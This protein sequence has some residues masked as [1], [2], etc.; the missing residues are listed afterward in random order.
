MKKQLII[1]ITMFI[2]VCF[3]AGC[4]GKEE[5]ITPVI[6]KEPFNLSEEKNE[7]NPETNALTASGSVIAVTDEET[8]GEQATQEAIAVSGSAIEEGFQSVDET[9]YVTE[10]S[11]R[12]RTS[13][14]TST[15]DNIYKDGV[16]R[17]YT[18]HR[19]GIGDVWSK[20][21]IDNE[22]YYVSNQ[23]ITTENI[24]NSK[25]KSKLIVIDAG[26]QAKQNTETEPIGPGASESKAKVAAG[27]TG[28]VSG[29]TEYELNLQVSLKLEKE[30]KARGYQ[31]QM[32]RTTHDVNISNKER[33]EIANEAN[34][35][36]FIR[37]HANGAENTSTN[38]VLLV[39]PTK[40]NPYIGNLYT[41]C[42][43]LSN[44]ILECFVEKTEANNKGIWETD[45]MSGINWCTVPVSIVELGFM[46]NAKE[47]ALMA[48]EEY[49]NKMAQ[50]I[51]DGIDKYFVEK[52]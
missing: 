52:E 19:V 47:D 9:V 48:T 28:C 35:D 49:Q 38:G 43:A 31:V 51:A 50:G 13:C 23:Y 7:D 42:R 32:I 30:L 14:D 29:L 5:K 22:Y 40:N 4:N 41:E 18:L 12:I 1:F 26:H 8:T 24:S 2:F 21:E 15:T 37:I 6:T 33:A 34:A 20:I 3:V 36:A 11:V 10:D 27:T 45:T 16:K 25:T 17:G 46:S 44:A 39:A